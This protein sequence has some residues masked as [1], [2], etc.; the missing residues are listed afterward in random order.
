ME[1]NNGTLMMVFIA[2]I[3]LIS[4]ILVLNQGQTKIINNGS[5]Q[6]NAI[7]VSGNAQLF[8]EPDQAEVYVN[9]ETFSDAADK[10][11]K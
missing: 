2:G 8:V 1:K 10:A 7:T 11:K 5:E 6:Q 9:I 3:I 4:V